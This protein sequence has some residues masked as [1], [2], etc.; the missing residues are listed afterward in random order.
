MTSKYL[1]QILTGDFLRDSVMKDMFRALELPSGSRGLDAGCGPGLQCV[2]MTQSTGPEGHVT[3]LDVQREFLEYGRKAAEESGVAETVSFVQGGIQSIPVPDSAFDWAWSSDCVGYGPWEPVPLLEEL[4]R[5]TR[6]G[7]RLFIAAWS[8]ENLLPG[9]PGIEARLK[10]TTAGLAPFSADAPPSRH[11]MKLTGFLRKTGL[12]DTSVSTFAGTVRAPLGPE[13]HEA[14]ESL[15][16]MRWDGAEK[17]LSK[18]DKAEF[19]RLLSPESPDF[20]L[21]D[22]DYYAFFTYSVFSGTVPDPS[23]SDQILSRN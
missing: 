5:V 13:M 2:L 1:K 23:I 10:A 20:I 8:S 21:K 7:G 4:I 11:F 22:P 18:K 17:E 3:G 12:V 16:E 19:K 9:Y 6:P 15:F 14:L